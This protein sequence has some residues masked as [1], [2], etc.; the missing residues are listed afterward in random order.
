MKQADQLPRGALAWI[1]VAQALLLVPHVPHIPLWVVAVYLC[2][3]AWRVQAF[4]GR[5]ELPGRWVK[6]VMAVAVA[7]GVVL[8]YGSLLG[9]EPM[10]AYLL[11]SFALKLT[12][13]NTRKD[14]YVVVFLGYFV[15]LVGFLFTQ[16]LLLVVYSLILV[17]VLTAALISV[18][19]R[20]A[21]LRDMRHL[22]LSATML[23][24]A[25]PLMLVLF[26]LFPRI[27]P[28]WVVPLK[29]HSAKTGMSDRL[30]PGD[31][32]R[33]SQ[34]DEVAFRA[35]FEGEIPPK[36]EL[37]WRGLV[38]SAL[39]ESGWRTLR[40]YEV[41]ASE[42]VKPRVD[43]I[44]PRIDYSV[45][46]N[47]TQQNWLFSLRHAQSKKPG[48]MNLADHRL[49]SAVIV[50][51]KLLYDVSSWPEAI[52]D[53]TLSEW[54]REIETQLDPVSNPRTRALARS[55]WQDSVIGQTDLL[56]GELG[57][58][59]FVN[60]VL[61]YFRE[62]A[63]F[64]TL[65]PPRLADSDSMDDFLFNSRRGFCE[66]YAYA[67]AVMMR[68]VGV[69]TR[70][71]GGYLGGEINPVNRT[72]IV[73]Q[74]DAHAWNEVWIEGEG[75]VRVDPTA[76]V[77][78][79]RILY[80]LEQAVAAEGSFL[81]DTP[82]SPLRFRGVDWV[83]SLRLRYDALTYRWQS[84]VVGFDGR[85]QES[86]LRDV[87]GGVSVRKSITVLL[88]TGVLTMAMV[89][90]FLLWRRKPPLRTGFAAELYRF[91]QMLYRRGLAQVA[92]ES[93]A[94]MT[95]RAQAHW[96]KHAAELSALHRQLERMTYAPAAEPVD[97][98]KV[99][100]TLRAR[101]RRLQLVL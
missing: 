100:R 29:S 42:R 16:D 84:W 13:M 25:F 82:L 98:N 97:S 62:N 78:P 39:D 77:S 58:R 43:T 81:S 46:L 49:Y 76:A 2:A 11:T 28:L 69:P 27:P 68:S 71:V 26:F 45:I 21:S 72:V 30:Q 80:G 63:F 64:Y 6:V 32:S 3:F 95:V 74:F 92:G 37:Y 70:V 75:W 52:L 35:S 101:L 4:R 53:P 20:S 44:G 48:I 88:G 24:Q 19:R 1:I 14:A 18:H 38:M 54:R 60:T 8:S 10:V 91:Q 90:A 94:Q 79:D 57:T 93:S 15:C 31:V 34:S 66:H 47:P 17:W 85:G 96:P 67:F 73:H 59:A 7:G 83:N 65:Q 40:Y 87:L 89:S 56:R 50:E 41:P 22:K 61:S 86:F 5:M 36:N 33:L 12:E 51:S 23:M 55:L 99:K 9:L